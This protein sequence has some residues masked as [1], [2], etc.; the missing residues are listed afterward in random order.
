[1]PGRPNVWTGMAI[2]DQTARVLAGVKPVTDEKIPFRLF[3]A[4]NVGKLNLKLSQ[5]DPW[6][7]SSN[8]LA[9]YE[10]IWGPEEVTDT[11]SGLG[12]GAPGDE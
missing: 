5:T 11:R 3:T 9:D 7:T 2:M 10:R 12:M 4:G 8:V 6:Y 1:M